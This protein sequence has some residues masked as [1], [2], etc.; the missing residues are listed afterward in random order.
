M[1]CSQKTTTKIYLV[2]NPAAPAKASAELQGCA[3]LEGCVQHT[4]LS[5]TA[6]A[7]VPHETTGWTD[8]SVSQ[9]WVGTTH[10]LNT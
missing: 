5:S 3:H 7:H 1:G 2:S 10:I 8:G 9:G 4:E 6:A